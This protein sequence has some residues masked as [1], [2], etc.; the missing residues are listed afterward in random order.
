MGSA[1]HEPTDPIGSALFGAT[2]QAV[3]R[4]LFGHTA[5]RFYQRQIIR[6]LRLGSGTVQRE[7]ERLAGAGILTRNV[8][9]RQTYFQ[10]NRKCPVFDP[11]RVALLLLGGDKTGD[12]HWYEKNVP[13]ADRLYDNY[14]AE[15]EEEDDAKDDK[16]Q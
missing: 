1:S 13:L 15:I 8:E 11:R 2:R 14:L 10:A 6:S 4:L 7:L 16:V 5:R 12:D 9:G 3:L